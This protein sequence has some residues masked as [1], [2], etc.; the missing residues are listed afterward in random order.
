MKDGECIADEAIKTLKTLPKEKRLEFAKLIGGNLDIPIDPAFV[1]M[2][3][4]ASNDAE[5]DEMV[6]MFAAHRAAALTKKGS[7]PSEFAITAELL[8][9]STIP[10]I[11]T[12]EPTEMRRA[13]KDSAAN[14]GKVLEVSGVIHSIR[15]KGNVFRGLIMTEDADLVHFYT[16]GNTENLFAQ[17]KATFVGICIGDFV[18]QVAIAGHF[19][20]QGM[21]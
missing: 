6:S 17:S 18:G 10:H 2:R 5:F 14:L 9:R 13:K 21:D 4:S 19:K 8:E 3:G 15:R 16:A 1:R 20:G 7:S 12:L 11:K